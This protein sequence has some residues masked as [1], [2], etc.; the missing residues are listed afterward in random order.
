MQKSNTDYAYNLAVSLDHLGK[1]Q[2]AMDYYQLSLKLFEQS[3]GNVMEKDV[4]KRI[5]LIQEQIK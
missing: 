3:G 4:K 2:H 1:P 5:K